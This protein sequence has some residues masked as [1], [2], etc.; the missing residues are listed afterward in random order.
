MFTTDLV[1]GLV[2]SLESCKI[3]REDSAD[4]AAVHDI[5]DFSYIR[6]CLINYLLK[7]PPKLPPSI[8]FPMYLLMREQL[9]YKILGIRH[10]IDESIEPPEM[11]CAGGPSYHCDK[12]GMD[13]CNAY[14]M[15][16]Q[17]G[18]YEKTFCCYCINRV[19]TDRNFLI[20][21]KSVFKEIFSNPKGH[22]SL[23]PQSSLILMYRYLNVNELLTRCG[24]DMDSTHTSSETSTH[25]SSETNVY[26]SLHQSLQIVEKFP[27]ESVALQYCKVSSRNHVIHDKGLVAT[28]DIPGGT[29][30]AEL[31][32]EVQQMQQYEDISIYN[33]FCFYVTEETVVDCS[34]HDC[35]IRYINHSCKPNAALIESWKSMHTKHVFLV[36]L[37]ETILAGS[38]LTVDYG[39]LRHR[40]YP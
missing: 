5:S 23:N 11:Y 17:K 20:D 35:P 3:L 26:E 1:R 21:N 24:L 33:H 40:H 36:S 18:S 34:Q 32:G 19:L 14:F 27:M 37:A 7:T 31:K 25:T 2:F 4:K 38:E 9:E 39:K 28:R 13:L 30:I 8:L 16:K 15:A 22:S 12:C 10:N 6:S 29:F